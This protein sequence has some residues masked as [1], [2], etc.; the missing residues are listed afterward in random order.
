MLWGPESGLRVVGT[1]AK[2][3]VPA[4][5]KAPLLPPQW[6]AA[7]QGGMLASV[8]QASDFFQR[9]KL[10]VVKTKLPKQNLCSGETGPWAAS[11]QP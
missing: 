4:C 8:A 2:G 5:A 7:T 3:R 6:T 1:V 9:L 10:L 11:W